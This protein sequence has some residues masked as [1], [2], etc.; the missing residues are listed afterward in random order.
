MITG[1]EPATNGFGLD[2]LEIHGDASFLGLLFVHAPELAQGVG[3]DRA[4]A[5]IMLGLGVPLKTFTAIPRDVLTRPDAVADGDG[6][7]VIAVLGHTTTYSKA[8][9]RDAGLLV[10]ELWLRCLPGHIPETMK[11]TMNKQPE[12][13]RQGDVLLIPVD[14]LPRK[15]LRPMPRER[16]VVLAHGEVTGHAHAFAPGAVKGYLPADAPDTE[17]QEA[18]ASYIEVAEALAALTHEEHGTIEVPRGTY[19]CVIQ[20]EYTPQAIRRVQD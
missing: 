2:L 9:R 6:A 19:R 8:A 20:S 10:P 5:E 17:Q 18:E 7:I 4:N 11:K 3:G 15:N 12:I 13:Y 14:E 16:R 1:H